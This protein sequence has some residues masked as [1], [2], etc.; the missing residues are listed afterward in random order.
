MLPDNTP[1]TINLKDKSIYLWLLLSLTPKVGPVTQQRLMKHFGTIE[2]IY[3][4]N[5]KTLSSIVNSTVARLILDQVSQADAE[6]SL[7]W[8]A[9]ANNN[10]IISLENSLYPMELTHISDAP[11]ILFL[12]GNIELLRQNKFAIVGT[13]HPTEQG[14]NNASRFAHDLANHGLTIVSGMGMPMQGMGSSA[15]L[16]GRATTCA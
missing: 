2:N 15:M 12:K 9:S 10:H 1:V 13:R 5:H 7:A 8:I 14:I 11:P 3:N 16:A 4:Q 6:E